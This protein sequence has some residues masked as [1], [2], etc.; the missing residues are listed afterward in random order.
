LNEAITS[1]AETPLDWLIERL[2]SAT[3]DYDPFAHYYLENV[4]PD[5]FYRE[6]IDRLP[7]SGIYQ[8]LFE[9]TTLKLDHFR[10]RDQRDLNQGWTDLLPAD[11]KAFWD[12][13]NAWFLGEKLARAVL[14]SFAEPLRAR[15]GTEDRWPE[16]SVE[17]QFIRHKA[18]YFL[19]PHSDLHTKLVVLLLYLAPDWEGAHLGT[20]LFRPK[21]PTFS[22][23]NSTH[24][25]FEDFV[26]V[27]TAPYRP[28]SVLAFVR[29]DVSF[30][31]VEPLSADDV[32]RSPRDLI[33]YV[34]Y[35]KSARDIQLEERRALSGNA[36]GEVAAEEA[37]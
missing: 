28:N 29:S 9:V 30:H 5:D 33:Q 17:A 34:I 12:R 14:R 18:G 24:Y 2:R 11:L 25:P 37:K 4:F 1:A 22:C 13:F 20:S 32:T 16:V 10:Y 15:I 31:G 6:M 35:D 19:G 7:G 27:K 36:A 3:I 8:N 23:P 21:D 26:K